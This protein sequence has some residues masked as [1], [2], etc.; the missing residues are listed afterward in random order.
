MIWVYSLLLQAVQ[1]SWY[2]SESDVA[3]S[4]ARLHSDRASVFVLG[5]QTAFTEV[6]YNHFFNSAICCGQQNAAEDSL[7]L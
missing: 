1:R 6:R 5:L 4:G 3:G 7:V 2:E